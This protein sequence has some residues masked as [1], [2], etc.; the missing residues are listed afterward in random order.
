M[1]IL[2]FLGLKPDGRHAT[3]TPS[4][5][6]GDTETVQ[7]IVRELEALEPARARYLAAFAYILGRVANADSEISKE[8]TGKMEE[9]LQKLGHLSPA[10]VIHRGAD[11]EEP[12]RPVWRDG[13]FPGDPGVQEDLD[14]GTTPRAPRLRV[15]RLGGGRI[16]HLGRGVTG[17]PDCQPAR[18]HPPTVC[19]SPG[20]LFEAPATSSS[21]SA[22]V[23]Q[24]VGRDDPRP[25]RESERL[26]LACRPPSPVQR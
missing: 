24:D 7:R 22:E 23:E 4:I 16:D 15:R 12:E 11:R 21:R 10:Q 26:V 14:A 5:E 17:A 3:E 8:E 6:V 25:V 20:G 13:K 9:V 18:V 1:S 2:E 19:G